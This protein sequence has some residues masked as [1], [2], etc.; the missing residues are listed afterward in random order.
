MNFLKNKLILSTMLV[1]VIYYIYFFL[2]QYKEIFY[3]VS[4]DLSYIHKLIWVFTYETNVM[5][6][7]YLLAFILQLIIGV[8]FIRSLKLEKIV[9]LLMYAMFFLLLFVVTSVNL[10]WPLGLLTS[11]AAFSIVYIYYMYTYDHFTYKSGDVIKEYGPFKSSEEAI[12][13]YSN[14]Y[15]SWNDYFH[16]H[17][18]LLSKDIVYEKSEYYLSISVKTF[19]KNNQELNKI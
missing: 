7:I 17:D 12:N 16:S 15:T 5:L 10:L 2:N 1:L 9:F 4:A 6:V 18:M 3:Y 8:L 14:F 11:I 13:M 19:S